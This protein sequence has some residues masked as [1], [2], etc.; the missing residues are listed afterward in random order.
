M[1]WGRKKRSKCPWAPLPSRTLCAQHSHVSDHSTCTHFGY[2]CQ[3]S[4][5][6]L[7][8][9]VYTHVMFCTGNH[10]IVKLYTYNKLFVIESWCASTKCPHKVFASILLNVYTVVSTAI[11]PYNMCQYK[12]YLLLIRQYSTFNV[13]LHISAHDH[14]HSWTL[15]DLCAGMCVQGILSEPMIALP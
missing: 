11:A 12:L 15:P 7:Y 6:I 5:S 1:S 2:G 10:N 3:Y 8:W 14:A 13:H 9:H 4:T